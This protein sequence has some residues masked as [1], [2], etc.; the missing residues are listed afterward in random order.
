MKRGAGCDLPPC[1]CRLDTPAL[2]RVSDQGG[3]VVRTEALPAGT[4]LRDRLR[5]ARENYA[6][7]AWTVGDLRPGQWA[8]LATNGAQR[9][10]VEIRPFEMATGAGSAG[11]DR[12]VTT[13]KFAP[14]SGTRDFA[15]IAAPGDTRMLGE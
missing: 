9:L 12:R 13:V 7:Q 15:R 11:L 5:I 14:N 8:F 3:R 2:L 10:I 4:D 6:R 1:P